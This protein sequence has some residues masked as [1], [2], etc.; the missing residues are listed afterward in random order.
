MLGTPPGAAYSGRKMSRQTSLGSSK[1]LRWEKLHP[2]KFEQSLSASTRPACPHISA[3]R[4]FM[5]SLRRRPV[6]GSKP[7]RS[8]PTCQS[9]AAMRFSAPSCSLQV[10]PVVTQLGGHDYCSSAD[11]GP[12]SFYHARKTSTEPPIPGLQEARHAA[13]SL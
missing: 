6:A 3:R 8:A 11:P 1:R 7:T 12:V 5:A 4:S 13:S 2:H 9:A 10:A